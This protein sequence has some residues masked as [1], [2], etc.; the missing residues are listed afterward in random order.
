LKKTVP[1]VV[2]SVALALGSGGC[3]WIFVQ[4]LP[5]TYERGDPAI[6]CTS[7]VAAPVIDTIFTVLDTVEL[8]AVGG[9]SSTAANKD[10]V[11]LGATLGIIIWGSSAIYGYRHTSECSDAQADAQSSYR[12]RPYR[13]APPP[14]YAPQPPPRRWVP[15]PPPSP[16]PPAA[17]EE[18]APPSVTVPGGPAAP[19]QRDDDGPN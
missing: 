18:A 13:R 8:I 16:P 15:P 14:A 7:N 5:P 12:Y 19:Q 6:N 9:S 17:P 4:P 3:S 1:V 11:L 2:L 10:S